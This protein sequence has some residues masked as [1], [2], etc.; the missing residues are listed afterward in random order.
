MVGCHF[1]AWEFSLGTWFWM[2][3]SH[4]FGPSW[5]GPTRFNTG[6]LS[7]MTVTAMPQKY[8][9][10]YSSDAVTFNFCVKKN[11]TSMICWGWSLREDMTSCP[12]RKSA[13]RKAGMETLWKKKE[14]WES[15]QG[16]QYLGGVHPRNRNWAI[17]IWMWVKME[18]LGDHRC[19]CLV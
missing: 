2:C 14:K 10:E 4:G 15:S 18:D 13:Q 16:C 8:S 12:S 3:P 7:N 6:N 1:A 11:E 17:I 5:D 9:C 19:E